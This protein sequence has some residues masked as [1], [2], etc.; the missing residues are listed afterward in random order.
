[1]TNKERYKQAFGAVRAPEGL[2]DGIM[3]RIE[4]NKREVTDMKKTSKTTKRIIA[5]LVA[6]FVLV[7]GAGTAYAAN[8]GGIQRTVQLWIHGDQTTATLTI[9][10]PAPD[11]PNSYTVS[12]TDADGN[13]HEM[14]GGG[15]AT[16][17][18]RFND[19]G[20]VWVYSLDQK[21]DITDKFDED[22]FCYVSVKQGRI[23]YYITVS[24]TGSAAINTSRYAQ[25][26]EV[27]HD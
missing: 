8:V 11:G 16:P 27:L 1:M 2:A 9:D 18:I 13:V 14:G 15:L 23:T 20:T 6:A 3:E 10:T 4:Q 19:D 5:G 24:R 7:I 17:D 21:I 22:G 25:P 26:S 12:Y